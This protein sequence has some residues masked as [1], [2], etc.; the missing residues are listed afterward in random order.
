MHITFKHIGMLFLSMTG[1]RNFQTQ[2]HDVTFKTIFVIALSVFCLYFLKILN[3]HAYMY[4]KSFRA[5]ECLF[6][7]RI[8]FNDRLIKICRSGKKSSAFRPVKWERSYISGAFII[9]Y[10]DCNVF[11]FHYIDT[12]LT[13]HE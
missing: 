10:F 4:I 2:L 11:I 1:C 12:Y 8:V 3:M 5:T 7:E 6:C 13:F 9:S